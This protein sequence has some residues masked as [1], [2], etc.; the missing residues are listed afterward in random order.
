MSLIDALLLD[1]AP[2]EVWIACRTDGLKGSGTASDPYDGS[3][4]AAARRAAAGDRHPHAPHPGSSRPRQVYGT[5]PP[6]DQDDLVRQ[7]ED[8]VVLSLL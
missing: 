8:A 4:A 3:T 6:Q 2:F 1:P 7:I 5:M